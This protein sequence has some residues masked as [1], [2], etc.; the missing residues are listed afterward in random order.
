M[1]GWQINQSVMKYNLICSLVCLNYAFPFEINQDQFWFF[2]QCSWRWIQNGVADYEMNTF[3]CDVH[4][5]TGSC[6]TALEHSQLHF[7]LLVHH[8]L[9]ITSKVKLECRGKNIS[10]NSLGRAKTRSNSSTD[11]ANVNVASVSVLS[12]RCIGSIE[13]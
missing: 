7:Q 9:T 11:N 8:E 5:C 3:A 4:G 12:N 10:D 13:L 6:R 2:F 1:V